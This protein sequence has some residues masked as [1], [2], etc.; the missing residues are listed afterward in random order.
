MPSLATTGDRFR[1]EFR[2]STGQTFFGRL[3]ASNENEPPISQFATARR[4]LRVTPACF[5]KAGDVMVTAA[6]QNFLLLNHGVNE[7]R[8]QVI[9]RT[10]RL[11]EVTRQAAWKRPQTVTDT[12]TQLK[13]NTVPQDLGQI[14]CLQEQMQEDFDRTI[15]VHED[16][17]RLITGA[18]L[19]LNDLIDDKTVKRVDIALGV[20]IAEIQ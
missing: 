5:V 10:F 4:L 2:I 1:S 11:V 20:S 13:K 9:Y 12:M 16:R 6:G 14:W 15:R 3:D 8:S 18:A 19:Q 7:V 17:W